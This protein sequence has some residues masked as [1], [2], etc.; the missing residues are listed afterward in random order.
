ME[1]PKNKWKRQL[2][3][4]SKWIGLGALFALV[5]FVMISV[6]ITASHEG[7]GGA[8]LVYAA[9]ALIV[10]AF[11]VPLLIRFFCWLCCWQNFRRFLF[12]VACL[13][14]LIALFYAIENF[15]GKRAWEKH[16]NELEALGEK[17]IIM[18]LAPPMV[19]EAQNFAL[20]P[21]L[22]PVLNLAQTTNG[23]VW[24]DTNGLA[25]LEKIQT[26]L[27]STKS[28]FKLVL[29][30]LEKGTLADVAN[31][32]QF[33]RGNT[34]YP[35]PTQQHTP[36][37][38]VLFSLT[39]FDAEIQELRAASHSRPLVRYPIAYDYEPSWAIL[40]PHLTYLKRLTLLTHMRAV[41]ELELR[42]DAEAMTDL[43]LGFRISDSIRDEP[44]LINHLVRVATL[45]INLQVIR[46][47]LVRHALNEAQLI[48]LQDYLSSLDILA[49]YKHAMRGERA[50]NTSGIDYLRRQRFQTTGIELLVREEGDL[51]SSAMPNLMPSGWFYQNMLAISQMHQNFVLAAV[52][53][54]TTRVFPDKCR[55]L[56][57]ELS[58]LPFRPYTAFAKMLMLALSNAASKS[59]RTEFFVSAARIA[60]ALERHRLAHGNYPETLDALMP[61]FI[62]KLPHDVINGQPLK[63]RRNADASFIL[64]SVGW[65]EKDDGG[66][67][68]MT[69]GKTPSV[70][71]K[72]G[73]WVWNSAAK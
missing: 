34:N 53:E 10:V 61:Q 41:S 7:E 46:E 49:E 42:R 63:Y 32:Q 47:A 1:T 27:G 28:E 37:E 19:A 60:I 5:L 39:R 22:K 4:K 50:F 18:E 57:V 3:G 20:T 73:D 15:R 6:L 23:I 29:G 54:K 71:P 72:K 44:I 62:A 9:L 26:D 48:E 30:S 58:N 12:G 68:V 16:R 45:S 59:A 17:F 69:T 21:L 51:W 8:R 24:H 31:W 65:N 64:Y 70:D 25:R 52:D 56:D 35:Q 13:I 38:D 55:T 36:A 11:L 2:T 67:V 14:T 40:L 43:K 66:T 33:Y